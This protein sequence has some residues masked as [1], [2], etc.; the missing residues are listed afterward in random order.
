MTLTTEHRR[1]TAVSMADLKAVSSGDIVKVERREGQP[2][3]ITVLRHAADEIG[4]PE[5]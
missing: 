5:R 3:R 4:S 1:W 2:S